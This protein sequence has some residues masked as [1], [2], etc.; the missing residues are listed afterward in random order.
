ML[1]LSTL[2]LYEFK[3]WTPDRKLITEWRSKNGTTIVGKN[4][5]L[6]SSFGGSGEQAQI[7]TWYIGLISNTGSP[8]V[9]ESDTLASHAGW[10]EFTSYSG[11]RQEWVD[12][13]AAS[14]VKGTTT[15]SSFTFS[16]AGDIYGA[17]LCSA[18]TGTSGILFNTTV[19][20]AVRS[21]PNGSILTASYSIQM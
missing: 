19:F 17:F 12:A 4:Y 9:V 18:A 21:V 1:L 5:M 7:G 16:A 2:G 15:A 14:K 3:L 10:T 20:D 13:A 8:V 11:N 6:A